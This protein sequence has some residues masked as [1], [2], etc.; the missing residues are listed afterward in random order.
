MHDA[1]RARVFESLPAGGPFLE[2]G[3][4]DS[5]LLE[6]AAHSVHYLDYL[7]TAD[8]RGKYEHDPNVDQSRIVEIDFVSGGNMVS[9]VPSGLR[10]AGIVASHVVEHVPDLIGWLAQARELLVPGGI[11]SLVVPDKRY[12]FD[13]ARDVSTLGEVIGA[14]LEGRV[15]PGPVQVVQ[16]FSSAV[17]FDLAAAWAGT[18]TPADLHP[19]HALDVAV[20]LGRQAAS[21]RYVDVHCWIHTPRSFLELMAGLTQHGFA[22]FSL[23]S[24]RDTAPGELEFYIALRQDDRDG[25]VLSASF[26]AAMAEVAA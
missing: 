4:L 12:T 15:R 1:R 26:E 22:G 10:F 16:F 25:S 3:P 7:S 19:K 13:R 23:S 17:R 9:A 5:P 18:L 21:G 8:L 2:V 11:L 14:H 24:F 6:K 20:E